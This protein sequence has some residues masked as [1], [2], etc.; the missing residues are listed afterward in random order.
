MKH[1]LN[2]KKLSIFALALVLFTACS[3]KIDEAYANPNATV[4]VPV[5]TLLPGIIGN[6]VGSSSAQGSAYGTANDG[7]YIGRYVQFWATN[8]PLNQFDQMGGATGGSDLLGSIWAMHYYG[9]GANL[10][11]MIEWSQ[12]EGKTDFVAVGW[13][14]SI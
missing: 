6:F 3:K 9:I 14:I 2:N 1:I 11:R 12:E 10:S 4:R 7:L 5:E 13:Y 8:V